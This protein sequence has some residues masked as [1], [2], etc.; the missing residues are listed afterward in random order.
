MKPDDLA[1]RPIWFWAAALLSLCGLSTA[2]VYTLR[3]T[4]YTMVLFMMAGQGLI[5]LAAACFI[6]AAGWS[7]RARLRSIE[8]KRFKAGDVVFRQGDYPDRLYVIGQG[9]VEV[10]RETPGQ[11]PAVLT[12]LGKDEFFGEIG[13]L[14]D[15]PRT[16]TVRAVTDVA[17]LSIHRSY[18]ASLLSY[19]PMFRERIVVAYRARTTGDGR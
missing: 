5:A 16:A 3:F 4:P 14:G 17:V 1:A 18:F 7:I 2:V 10:V 6:A 13:I 19:L 9:E 12:R 8:E 15:T 11:E